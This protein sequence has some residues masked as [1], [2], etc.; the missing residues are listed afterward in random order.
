M[1]KQDVAELTI[2]DYI[3]EFGITSRDFKK[4]LDEFAGAKE[5]HGHFDCIGGDV[6]QGF[7]IYNLILAHPAPV[8]IAYIDGLAYSMGSIIPMAFNQVK[9]ADTAFYGIHNP[10]VGMFGNA[11]ELRKEADTL[12]KM[13]DKSITAYQ[14]HSHLDYGAIK[15]MMDAET[16]M[17][18]DEAMENGFVTEIYN[19][20]KDMAASLYPHSA[21]HCA[22]LFSFF[23]AGSSGLNGGSAANSTGAPPAMK[24]NLQPETKIEETEM[25]DKEIQEMKDKHESDM[26]A[27]SEELEGLKSTPGVDDFKALADKYGYDFAKENFGKTKEEIADAVIALADGRV[28]E[29]ETANAELKNQLEEKNRQEPSNA[30]GSPPPPFN[31]A[32]ENGN[33]APKATA[34]E[35][36]VLANLGIEDPAEQDKVIATGI[37][38]SNMKMQPE[39]ND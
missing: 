13:R 2:Y 3:G 37:K 14:R 10:W 11:D 31:P 19:T 9:I 12:D 30:G 1:L 18:S 15:E 28:S 21:A 25:T 34:K 16:M 32:G 22:K 29:L 8:K 39:N 17:D 5:I 38:G 7:A 6:H 33:P 24:P 23:K 27:L 26:A 20:P 35:R 36:E 4:S